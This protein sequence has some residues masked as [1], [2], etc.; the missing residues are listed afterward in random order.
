MVLS[1]LILAVSTNVFGRRF[2]VFGKKTFYHIDDH[3]NICQRLISLGSEIPGVSTV[4]GGKKALSSQV[5][6][7]ICEVNDTE[8][9]RVNDNDY[10]SNV[11]RHGFRSSFSIILLPTLTHG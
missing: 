6:R 5:V 3:N 9:L 2:Y 7:R 4:Y 8:S 11:K 1:Q 10:Y